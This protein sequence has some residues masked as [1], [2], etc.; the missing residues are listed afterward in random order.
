MGHAGFK[1]TDTMY[2]KQVAPSL[3]PSAQEIGADIS[4]GLILRENTRLDW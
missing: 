2:L 4:P 3:S 1:I